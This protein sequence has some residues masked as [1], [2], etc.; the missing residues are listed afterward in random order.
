MKN[1]KDYAGKIQSLYRE[2]KRKGTKVEAVT[3]EDPLEA[4]IY[5]VLCEKMSQAESLSAQKRLK[6]NFVDLNDLRVSSMLE[7]MEMIGK[8]GAEFRETAQ[9]II[10]ILKLVFESYN[11]VSLKELVA[12]GKRPAKQSLEKIEGVTKFSVDYCFL[13][14][15]GGHVIPLTE[16]MVNYLKENELVNPDSDADEIE[17][18]LSRQIAAK[19]GYEFY[20]LVREESETAGHKSK[21]KKTA[22]EKAKAKNAGKAKKVQKKAKITKG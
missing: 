6:K 8:E 9:R 15:L 16:R 12:M 22:P 4:L 14:S 2:L 7:I 21:V 5:G 13:T 10:N 1:S 18:F 19:N 11:L 3:Y 17:G 20:A